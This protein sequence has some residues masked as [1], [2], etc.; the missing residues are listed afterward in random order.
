MQKIV[1]KNRHGLDIVIVITKPKNSKGV[2]LLMHGFGSYKEHPIIENAEKIFNSHSFIT[3]KFDATKSI[4][5]SGGEMQDG[6]VTSYC[7]DLEDVMSWVKMQDWHDKPFYLV[8]HSLGGY[9]VANYIANCE[10]EVMGAILF[11]PFISG[12]LFQETKEIKPILSEWK[13]K[14][15]REWESSSSPGI[16]KKSKYD[17]IEDSLNHD[18]LKNAFK[19][20]TPILLIVSED[21]TTIPIE[22]QKLLFENL[23]KKQLE[24]L[25]DTNH[26]LKSKVDSQNLVKLIGSWINQ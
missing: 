15:I 26:N 17:F 22:H 12:K 8:G 11:C 19:I 1:I 4:G 10:D 14:G 25:K 24:I 7:D 16:I 9:C 20:K 3:V 6:T 13:E 5:E 23:E 2:V 18:L 21:D